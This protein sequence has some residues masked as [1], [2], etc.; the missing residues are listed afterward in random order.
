MSGRV[1]SVLMLWQPSP[2]TQPPTDSNID[3]AA[4][5]APPASTI[6]APAAPAEFPDS[7]NTSWWHPQSHPVPRV[8]LKRANPYHVLTPVEHARFLGNLVN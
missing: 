3:F 1:E 4:L 7:D 8:R 2:F 5:A 6:P